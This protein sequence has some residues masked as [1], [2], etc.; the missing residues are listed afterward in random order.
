[1]LKVLTSGMALSSFY[2]NLL[3]LM[4]LWRLGL[5]RDTVP[6]GDGPR[7]MTHTHPLVVKWHLHDAGLGAVHSSQ[8]LNFTEDPL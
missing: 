2:C 7:C 1:M 3:L 6:G 5:R 8:H 4:L